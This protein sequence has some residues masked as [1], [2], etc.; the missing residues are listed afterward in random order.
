MME[1]HIEYSISDF[2]TETR[3]GCILDF[4]AIDRKECNGNERRVAKNWWRVDGGV[5]ET[6]GEIYFSSRAPAHLPLR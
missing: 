4:G 3:Q 5:K 2:L 1:Y 6:G